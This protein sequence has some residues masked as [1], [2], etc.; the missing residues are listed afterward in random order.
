MSLKRKREEEKTYT[1]EEIAKLLTR[2]KNVAQQK[3]GEKYNKGYNYAK[4]LFSQYLLEMIHVLTEANA[5]FEIRFESDRDPFYRMAI[6][7]KTV[8]SSL[9]HQNVGELLKLFSERLRTLGGSDPFCMGGA[10]YL[11]N[12]LYRCSLKFEVGEEKINEMHSNFRVLFDF[13]FF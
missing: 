12:I 3:R 7:V 6:L 9:R 13:D 10:Q 5:P 1:D 11:H 8:Y 4:K 2:A